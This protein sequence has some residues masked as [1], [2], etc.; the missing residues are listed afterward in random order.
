MRKRAALTAYAFAAAAASAGLVT[1]GPAASVAPQLLFDGRATRMAELWSTGANDQ[2]MRPH[3]WDCLCFLNNDITLVPDS[4][5]G[6]VYS[7]RAGAGSS[8]PWYALGAAKAAAQTS[9]IRP[10]RLGKWDWYGIAVRIEPGF[11]A[12]EWST[13]AQFNYP[14]LSAPPASLN[15]HVVRSRLYWTLLRNAGFLFRPTVWGWEGR[16]REEPVLIPAEIGK[17]TEFV[18]GIRWASDETGQ[19]RVYSRVRDDGQQR[20]HLRLVRRGT[21]TWQYGATPSGNVRPDGTDATSGEQ[22]RTLDVQGLYFGFSLPPALFPTNRVLERGL[23]RAD[24]SAAVFT[25]MP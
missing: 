22:H 11:T 3:V 9:T 17:W 2:R 12:P 14:S 24:S 8:N 16:V 21:P 20:F 7:V 19:I 13:V 10:N 23:I 6:K 25:R 18:I 4:R 15:L 5:Y 1:S